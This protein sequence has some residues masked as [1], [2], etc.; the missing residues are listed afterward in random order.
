MEEEKK[1]EY[2]SF[3]EWKKIMKVYIK[4][5]TERKK[6]LRRRLRTLFRRISDM[7]DKKTS[8]KGMAYRVELQ[9]LLRQYGELRGD[10]MYNISLMKA[11]E[12][13]KDEAIFLIDWEEGTPGYIIVGKDRKREIESKMGKVGKEHKKYIT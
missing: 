4:E 12:R 6:I 10:I 8:L 9:E 1:V 5:Q 11:A 7:G 2:V 13:I 3:E